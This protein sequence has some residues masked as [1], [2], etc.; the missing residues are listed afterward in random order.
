MPRTA[1]ASLGGMSYHTLNRGSRREALLHKPGEYDAFVEAR[2]DARTLR[3][4]GPAGL[5]LFAQPLPCAP[6]APPR[7]RSGAL[8]AVAAHAMR[9]ATVAITAPRGT[10]GWAA[11]RR[12]RWRMT[13][14]GSRCSG[15]SSAT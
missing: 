6:E 5:L 10:S 11:S 14:I 4:G 12:S 7:W 3:Q 1:R 15:T 8:D 13:L 9:A 2:T